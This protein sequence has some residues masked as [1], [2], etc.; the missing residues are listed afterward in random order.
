MPC[1]TADPGALD[2]DTLSEFLL[3]AAILLEMKSQ[4]LLPG[5]DDIEDDEELGVWD[6]RDLL[7]ARLLECQAYAAA[8]RRLRR[9]HPTSGALVPR[10][11]G[12][13]EGFVVHAPDLLAG[14]TPPPLAQAYLRA[15]RRAAGAPGRPVPRHRRHG[16]RGRRRSTTW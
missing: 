14:V 10:E 6:Q 15:D 13:D 3:V 2:L 16:D 11:A 9:P 4:R 1:S 12:L 8:V 7:V 5:P